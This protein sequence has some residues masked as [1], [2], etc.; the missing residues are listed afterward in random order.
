MRYS[1]IKKSSLAEISD[2]QKQSLQSLD[3]QVDCD[4]RKVQQIV[5]SVQKRI[6]NIDY[7]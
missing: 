5:S 2:H 3:C 7:E 6:Q 4:V 1:M